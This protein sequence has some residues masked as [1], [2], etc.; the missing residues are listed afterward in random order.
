MERWRARDTQ[1]ERE[2]ERLREEGEK[3]M[4]KQG[5]E[6]LHNL[7]YC[8]YC[9]QKEIAVCKLSDTAHNVLC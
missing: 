2:R 8:N 9:L 7:N 6:T 5:G 1:R 3:E 4:K